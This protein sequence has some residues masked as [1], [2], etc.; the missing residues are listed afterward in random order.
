[1]AKK[2][3]EKKGRVVLITKDDNKLLK[4]YFLD[5]ENMGVTLCRTEILTQIFSKGL[6]AIIKEAVK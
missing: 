4:Q 5:A 6:H 2:P 3:E 1:M